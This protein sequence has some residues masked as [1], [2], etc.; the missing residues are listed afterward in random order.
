[1]STFRMFLNQESRS[2]AKGETIFEKGDPADRMFVTLGDLL[3]AGMELTA[4]GIRPESDVDHEATRGWVGGYLEV[5]GTEGTSSIQVLLYSP[6]SLEAGVATDHP[7]YT[8]EG[9]AYVAQPSP[10]RRALLTCPGNLADPDSCEEIREDGE[11]VGRMVED[12]WGDLVVRDVSLL[13]GDG[14][15]YVGAANST[16]EKWGPD[17]EVSAPEP[18]LTLEQLRAIAEGPWSS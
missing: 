16:S 1:M 4:F 9:K 8:T 12:R 18:P 15:V 10:G 3:P 5:D 17:S 6:D 7:G 11:V 13:H 2:F 14:M